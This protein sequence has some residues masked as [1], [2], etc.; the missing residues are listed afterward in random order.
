MRALECYALGILPLICSSSLDCVRI[1]NGVIGGLGSLV[2]GGGRLPGCVERLVGAC[3]SDNRV[4][5]VVT[6]VLDSCVL[7]IGG[8]PRGLGPTI[9][10][11]STSSART[12]RKYLRCTGR[13]RNVYICFPD[14]TC[15]ADALSLPRGDSIAVFKRNEC[16][17]ELILENKMARPVLGN[18]IGAL[19]LANLALSNGN[20]VRMGGIGLVRYDKIG[21]DVSR[22]V[23]ASKFALTGL[24]SDGGVRVDRAIFSRTVRGTLAVTK[25]KSSGYD[26]V[27]FGSVSALIKGRFVGLS[28]SGGIV[29]YAIADGIA[30]LLAVGNGGGCIRVS[31]IEGCSG[32]TS[33]NGVGAIGVMENICG[34]DIGRMSVDN[35]GTGVSCRGDMLGKRAGARGCANSISLGSGNGVGG[36]YGAGRRVIGNSVAGDNMGGARACANSITAANMGGA[37][38]FDNGLSA[39]NMSGARACDNGVIAGKGSGARACANSTSV[40]TGVRAAGAGADGIRVNIRG[41]RGCAN[42]IRRGCS[43]IARAMGNSSTR[44]YGCGSVGTSLVSLGPADPLGCGAPSRLRAARFFDCVP[45]RSQDKGVIGILATGGGAPL[46]SSAVTGGILVVNSDCTRNCAPSKGMGKFPALVNRCTK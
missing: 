30:G 7:D 9:N 29:G 38:A 2:G 3:V 16:I 23:L 21:V 40:R 34:N 26:G 32:C 19:A 15:L 45:V 42:T 6:R 41:R 17:A 39:A 33:G 46:V 43:D 36:R 12:V 10:S 18:G 13:R 28:S 4:G 1:R 27:A 20:S 11:N 25:A 24:A 22:Y 31:N 37:R 5:G 35:R 8:P 44:A 14:N